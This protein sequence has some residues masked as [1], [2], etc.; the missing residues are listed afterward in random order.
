VR[1]SFQ[2]RFLIDI[3]LERKERTIYWACVKSLEGNVKFNIVN[4]ISI[5]L[6]K[7]CML[8]IIISYRISK[9]SHYIQ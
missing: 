2:H 6:F 1:D 9:Q 7:C 8:H 3:M 4:S 5:L